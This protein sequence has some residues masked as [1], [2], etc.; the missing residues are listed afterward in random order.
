MSRQSSSSSKDGQSQDEL[1]LPKELTEDWVTMDVC[2]DCKKFIT[3]IIS[4]SKRSLCVA[5]K[6]A[7]LNRNRM[8]QSFYVSSTRSRNFQPTE[9]TINEV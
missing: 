4:S 9:R 1:E 8:T 3:E 5:S 6:R 7:R 2:I